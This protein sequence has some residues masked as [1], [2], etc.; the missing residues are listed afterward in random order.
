MNLTQVLKDQ[1]DKEGAILDNANRDDKNIRAA[2]KV[3]KEVR[4]VL[5][6]NIRTIKAQIK[7]AD[8]GADGKK[9]SILRR[10]LAF[11]R[12]QYNDLF[13]EIYM[14]KAQ[15]GMVTSYLVTQR[16]LVVSLDTEWEKAKREET[17]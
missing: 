9:A 13:Q 12:E 4:K 3:S 2:I 8:R 7:E 15:L 6:E 17:V 10:S 11:F 1:L 14:L 16:E 5:A